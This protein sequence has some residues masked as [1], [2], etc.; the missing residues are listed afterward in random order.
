M[1]KLTRRLKVISLVVV[2]LAVGWFCWPGRF[3]CFNTWLVRPGMKLERVEW[4]LGAPGEEIPKSPVPSRHDGTGEISG[5]RFYRWRTDPNAF[6]D[7]EVI[8]GFEGGVVRDTYY[9]ETPLF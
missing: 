3:S 8:I 6:L 5:E 9:W 7:G 2:L 4:L 1:R